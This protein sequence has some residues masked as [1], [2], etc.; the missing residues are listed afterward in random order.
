MP[1]DSMK[2]DLMI[3]EARSNG[4]LYN[5]PGDPDFRNNMEDDRWDTYNEWIKEQEEADELQKS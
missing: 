3:A 1:N 5:S 4:Y 2:Y